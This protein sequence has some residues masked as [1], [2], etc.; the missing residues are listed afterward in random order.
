MKKMF[1]TLVL[2]F[3]LTLLVTGTALADNGPHG[4]FSTTTAAC[5]GCHRTHTATGPKLLT[6]AGYAICTA[7]HGTTGTGANTNVLDGIYT[8]RTGTATEGTVGRGLLAGGFANAYMDTNID[9]LPA[10]AVSAVTT[11]S[12]VYNGL[13]AGTVWAYGAISATANNGQAN[14]ALSCMNCHDPHG[15]AGVITAKGPTYRILR[16]IPTGLLTAG[17]PAAAI[18]VTDQVAKTYTVSSTSGNYFT[19]AYATAQSTGLTSWCSQC[20]TR[21][22]TGT[23]SGSTNSGD[24]VF[25]FRHTSNLAATGIA[26]NV[27][28]L[29]C[30]SCH[31]AHGSS[32]LMVAPAVG[33]G[34]STGSALLRVDNR[35]VCQ[36]CHNK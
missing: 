27:N 1:V 25:M 19:Q 32:A 16:P 18:D 23:G 3:T 17:F 6:G 9:G 30:T 13:T 24:A 2:V 15:K 11:S 31:V 22:L 36:G 5:A 14:T 20:H 7:C 26:P 8:N 21:D 34:L 29:A 12:H 28:G 4:G 10:T 33:V 35:G